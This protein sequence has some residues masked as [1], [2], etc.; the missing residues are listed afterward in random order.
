MSIRIITCGG[1]I[2]AQSIS[3]NGEYLFSESKVPLILLQ[4]RF[5]GPYKSEHLMM[6]DSRDMINS[7]RQCILDAC[8][9]APESKILITHG[10]DT[11]A[12]TGKFLCQ[13][14]ND[15]SLNGKTIVL[16]GAMVPYNCP[17]S[18]AVFNIGSA[19]AYL[20]VL[21]AG[22]YLVMHGE[23]FDPFKVAKDADRGVFIRC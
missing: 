11:M 2:D 20:Q 3:S 5:K 17:D 10:T 12:E 14:L 18:D 23:I 6:V 19:L 13:S 16:T 9:L 21:S 1:T 22:V 8:I 15:K 4:G 7:H